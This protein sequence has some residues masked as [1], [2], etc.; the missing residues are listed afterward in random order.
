MSLF[1][2]PYMT[3]Q[4]EDGNPVSG[5]KLFFYATET[6]TPASVYAD[7]GLTTPLT[8][9]V[10]ADSAGRC[11]AVY[12][13][14]TVIYRCKVTTAAGATIRDVDPID[15][16]LSALGAS[17][18]S[19]LVTFI[20]AGTGA[21]ARTAQSKMRDVIHAKDFGVKA[22]NA[23]DDTA[24]FQAALDAVYAAG[25]GTLVLPAGIILVSTVSKNWTSSVTV[26]IQ[27]AGKMAT[28]IKK[29]G[30]TTTP[31]L[32]LSC[33]LGILE[34]Y[35]TIADLRIQGLAKSSH[36]IRLTR[37][38][39]WQLERVRVDT[40]DV[41]VENVGS[42]VFSVYD[43]TL[44]GNNIGY[45]SRKS[46]SV[47]CNLIQFFGGTVSGNSTFGLDIGDASGV[48]ILGTDVSANGTAAD[49]STGGMVLRSTM[50]DETGFSSFTMR[51]AW[52]EAN[53]GWSLKVEAAS[54]LI[55]DI[56]DAVIAASESGRAA[57]IG[58]IYSSRL[59]GIVAGSAADTITIAAARSL[60][61]NSV[62]ATLTDTSTYYRHLNVG[63]TAEQISDTG[64]MRFQRYKLGSQD[65]LAGRADNISGGSADSF[66]YYLYGSGEI[67]FWCGG[68]KQISMG[69]NTLGFFG[70]NPIVKQS[71]A[72]AAT[73]PATTMALVNDLRAKL[74]ATGLI[75]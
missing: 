44:Q 22:D 68:A 7:G 31:I 57:D 10:V 27:G 71:V 30:V 74:I 46:V 54:G 53:Y 41:G 38:A 12:L 34:T 72:A 45:R 23:T 20:Q 13:D 40:C 37:W 55:I 75:S 50:D 3:I 19:S 42:L 49:T 66:D 52:L 25:G 4:D 26:R 73:D 70:T 67:R 16:P 8:N 32:D 36:G 61:M 17:D 47:Y 33:D 15:N 5:G 14:P 39:R 48:Q 6:S 64:K 69:S 56:D 59:N 21:V 29:T 65:Y 11:A 2:P 51:G 62:I 63:T 1:A 9:P 60:V 58:A 35:C 43:P 18:G 28:T 24:A